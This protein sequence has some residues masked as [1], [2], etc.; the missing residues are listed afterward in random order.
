MGQ[1]SQTTSEL[2][3]VPVSKAS[4]G[5]PPGLGAT[6]SATGASNGWVPGTLSRG[7]SQPSWPNNWGHSTWL[8]LKNLTPQV[9]YL[10]L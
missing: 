3:G 5:P 4:R 2:W 8:L 1:P 6:K 7:I 10:Q 9:I